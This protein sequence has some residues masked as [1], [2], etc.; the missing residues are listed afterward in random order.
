MA[1]EQTAEPARTPQDMLEEVKQHAS[2]LP[3]EQLRDLRQWITREQEPRLEAQPWVE[4]AQTKV[5]VELR[6][7]GKLAPPPAA[8]FDEV[9]AKVKDGKTTPA[10]A[11]GRIP[12]WEDPG[13]DHS[14]MYS[15]GDVVKH[16]ERYWRSIVDTLNSWEPGT[17]NGLTWED[18][19]HIVKPGKAKQQDKKEAAEV[20]GEAPEEPEQVPEFVQPTGAH[21]AYP[22]GA[23]VRFDGAVY[24]SAVDG[25]AFSPAAYPPN[26]IKE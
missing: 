9:V 10:Q 12:A 13:T 3:L 8:K 2:A 25:N 6:E 5:V 23:R 15:L 4:E 24:V 14:A 11:A 19:T 21:D 26:W 20:A 1:D 7:N 22:K 16:N 18:I 17:E